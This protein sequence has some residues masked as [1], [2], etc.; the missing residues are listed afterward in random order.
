ML[1]ITFRMANLGDTVPLQEAEARILMLE[2]GWVRHLLLVRGN[3][4]ALQ[5]SLNPNQIIYNPE[6]RLVP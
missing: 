3:T 5:T 4:Y 2:D 1:D 6:I